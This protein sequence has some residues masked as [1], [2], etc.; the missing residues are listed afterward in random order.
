M[1]ELSVLV[2]AELASEAHLGALTMGGFLREVCERHADRE[3]LCWRDGDGECHRYSY[4]EL[5]VESERVAG[6]LLAAG[7]SKDARVG[8]LVS[9][10]P[11]WLFSMFGAAMAGAVTVALNTFSTRAE[12]AYQ[13]QHADVEALIVENVVASNNF[14]DELL[15]LCPQLAEAAPGEL[16]CPD[17]PYL[18]LV[19]CTDGAMAVPG[20]LDWSA[21][22]AGAERVPVN[23]LAAIQASLS[24]VDRGFIFFSSGTTAKPKAIVQTQRAAAL[25]CWRFGR[26][27]EID[28]TVRTWSANGFF[29]SGNF[30]MALGGTLGVGGCLVLQGFFDPE[31]T[32]QLIQDEAVTLPIAWP[33]QDA[34]LR[35]S[36]NWEDYDLSSLRYVDAG[37]PLAEHPSVDTSWHQPQGYG[38]TET[39]TFVTGR[40]ASDFDPSQGDI[41]P[42]NS[43]QIVDPLSGKLLPLGES[44]EI[45]VKGPTL[46]QGL[47][48]VPPE[49][50]FDREGF[51]H[52][53]DAGH[54]GP[55]G[56]L[57][58]EGRL[59]DIVKT[60]GANV[61]PAEIDV[62][63]NTHEA[64]HSAFSVGVPHDTLGEMLVACVVLREGFA[65]SEKA[66]R[67][68]ARE[69]LASY[70]VPRR[71]L[72][73]REPELPMTGSNKVRRGEL[74]GRAAEI[75]KQ[76]H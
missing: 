65:L 42:G 10:R 49:A 2:G 8:V 12:L 11:E 22:I 6:A 59:N 47:L 15:T 61:S 20:A 28:E 43:L 58:W 13:L 14:V 51:F 54:I 50:S 18:R 60:G 69:T 16:L 38:T 44:G 25:Q 45:L 63:L 62:V 9:N 37:S 5:L 21:F 1:E 3:A 46:M 48:K 52:T 29:W 19:V 39:F 7:V 26:W 56:R 17:L 31:E 71:V 27:F 68:F 57:F 36:P 24:P 72:F 34:R 33:H 30:A 67:E 41:L 74:A 4:A 40:A 53:G 73:F 64:V 35:E 76:D 55:G 66:L 23:V 70:K 32:L 75:L